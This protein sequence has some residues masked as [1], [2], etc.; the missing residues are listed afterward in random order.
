MLDIMEEAVGSN[1]IIKV[2]PKSFVT[3]A[4]VVWHCTFIVLTKLRDKALCCDH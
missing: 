1:L 3:V 4:S 2:F